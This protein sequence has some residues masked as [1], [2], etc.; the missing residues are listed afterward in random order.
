[1]KPFAFLL[2]LAASIGSYAQKAEP[3]PVT[4]FYYLSGTIDKYPVTFLLH[5]INEE[6]SGGYYYHSSGT[7]IDIAGKLDK[8]G[9]LTLNHL[10]N[11]ENNNEVI[12]GVFKDSSFSGTWQSKGKMLSF[13]VAEAK[14]NSALQFDYIW[15]HGT[16]KIKD[17][18][19]HMSH[20]EGLSYEARTIWPAAGSKHP[21]KEL[22]QQNIRILYSEKNSSEEIG[23]ILIRNKNK[24]LNIPEDSIDLYELVEAVSIDYA[25]ARI[26]C[27]SQMWHTYSGGAHGMYGNSYVNLD[28][29]NN[30]RISL[31]D[32]IDTVAAKSTVEKML[33]QQFRKNFP[34]EEGE[35]LKDVLMVEKIPITENF[36]LTGKGIGFNYD[37]YEIAAYAYGQI[38]LIIPYKDLRS[39]LKPDFKKLMG[40]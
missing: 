13:R 12:E 30:R 2:L 15:T 6:F 23:K 7:P 24:F 5:R 16:R 26:I 40:L 39:Y 36:M 33:E 17:K 21:S 32:I 31:S 28:L 11:D 35:K 9:L 1:M 25:D 29:V 4:R 18:P 37:P 3:D 38:F 19:S 10:A 14:D 20:L 27:M 22:I 34:F 8:T